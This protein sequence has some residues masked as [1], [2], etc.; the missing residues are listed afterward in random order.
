LSLYS[1]R[2]IAATWRRRR[3][4]NV[5]QNVSLWKEILQDSIQW[6]TKGWRLFSRA[7]TM[8]ASFNSLLFPLGPLLL[9]L[10][11]VC[12]CMRA[13]AAAAA[14]RN[15]MARGFFS[16]MNILA[17]PLSEDLYFF[18]PS[19]RRGGP[20]RP[21]VR[22]SMTTSTATADRIWAGG[23]SMRSRKIDGWHLERERGY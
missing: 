16:G 11:G 3:R 18:P 1:V 22:P 5:F 21:S 8:R 23:G 17:P 12:K 2:P 13:A 9:S 10:N 6:R 4:K 19:L 15:Q 14:D 7:L 20:I